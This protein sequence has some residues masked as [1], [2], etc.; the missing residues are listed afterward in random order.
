M[1]PFKDNVKNLKEKPII[2]YGL[3]SYNCDA[4]YV[5]KTERTI[6]QRVHEH[7]KQ[8]SSKFLLKKR[9]TRANNLRC[10]IYH[11]RLRI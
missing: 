7:Q 3:K 6:S 5:G 8:D 10:S 11:K 1:F 2:V 9:I 4:E